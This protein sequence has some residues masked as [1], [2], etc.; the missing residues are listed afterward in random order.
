MHRGE[1]MQQAVRRFPLPPG[2]SRLFLDA[3]QSA[4]QCGCGHT[5]HSQAEKLPSKTA[6]V[7]G[8]WSS[9]RDFVGPLPEGGRVFINVYKNAYFGLV[10]PLSPEW[11]E[12]YSGPPPSD[13]GYLDLAHRV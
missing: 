6:F 3:T 9:A 1:K 8:A 13:S 10:N 12:K 5:I 2:N 4:G 11:T 7:K